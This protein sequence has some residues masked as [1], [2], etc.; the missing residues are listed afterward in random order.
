MKII[1]NFIILIIPTFLFGQ[2]EYHSTKVVA[3]EKYTSP[4]EWSPKDKHYGYY[5]AAFSMPIRISN[6][7]EEA[8]KSGYL[9]LGYTYRYKLVDFMDIGLELAYA[10]RYSRIDKDI[11]Y[12][13]T[14]TSGV[15][16]KD[17]KMKTYHNYAEG[18][19]FVRFNLGG[20]THRAL[21]WHVDFGGTF[22]Y[23]MGYGVKTKASRQN[24]TQKTKEK[25]PDYLSPENYGAYLRV[26]WNY[27]SVFCSYQ[28]GD[29]ITDYGNKSTSD[30]SLKDFN[31]SPLTLGF[32]LNLY[33][34]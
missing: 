14:H 18:G 24:I 19:I 25:R 32:Q 11:F 9:R 31:R 26:G 21:G 12:K 6:T 5:M 4:T 13:D 23:A 27:L 3:P 15:I 7:A 8:S 33:L 34:R 30:I 29:W 16:M 17:D 1:I 2:R 28:F 22:D 20:A 10:K